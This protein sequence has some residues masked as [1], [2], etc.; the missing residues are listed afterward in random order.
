MVSARSSAF[1]DVLRRCRLAAG[2]TQEELAERAGL[3]VR[4]I[5]DLER[6]VKQRPRRDTVSLL[7]DALGLTSLQ[8]SL[9][10]DAARGYFDPVSNVSATIDPGPGTA[11]SFP[12]LPPSS[13][14]TEARRTNLPAELTSFVGRDAEVSDLCQL[15]Q[16]ETFGPRLVTLTGTGGVG[17]T[18][19]ALCVGAALGSSYPDGVWLVELAPLADPRLVAP[20]VAATFG[21]H[22]VEGNDLSRTLA[23]ALQGRRLL[24]LLDNCEHLVA[25]CA[26]L[27][28]ALLEDCPGL[29]VVATSREILGVPGEVIWR[30]PSLSAPKIE[31]LPATGSGFVDV[32]ARSEAARLFVER[33]R[34][35]T[36]NFRITA[37]NA[38]ALARICHWLDGIPLAIELAA[39][40]L[41][42]IGVTQLAERFDQRFRLLTGGS[43]TV[44]RRQQTL[45]AT[46]DWSY[47]LLSGPER[48]LFRRLAVFAGGWTLDAAEAVCLGGEIEEPGTVFVLLGAL[49]DKSLVVVEGTDG[50]APRYRLLDTLREYAGEQLRTGD[51]VEPA[52]RAH[53]T[54]YLQFCQRLSNQVQGNPVVLQ[55]GFLPELDNFRAAL[56]W[57]AQASEWNQ[58]AELVSALSVSWA[59]GSFFSESSRWIDLM[60]VHQSDLT[61]A[62]R[63]QALVALAFHL[64][65]RGNF[66]AAGAL[67]EQGIAVYRCTGHRPALAWALE[68]LGACRREEGKTVEAQ[69]LLEEA[70][71]VL[72]ELGDDART[73]GPRAQL[74]LLAHRVG[75]YDRAEILLTQ[76]LGSSSGERSFLGFE[77]GILNNLGLIAEDRGDLDRAYRFHTRSIAYFRQSGYLWH[78]PGVLEGFA[79]LAARQF[80]AERAMILAGAAVAIR[81]RIGSPISPFKKPRFDQA[82]GR[83]CREL[84]DAALIAWE[85][86]QALTPEQAIA[87]ALA[88]N[89]AV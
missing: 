23:T 19:L 89:N 38:I 45:R 44:L 4:G 53:A 64:F 58:W 51:E 59:A 62:T 42:T 12:K 72:Q 40:C 86:G 17:K 6:G 46:V 7:A 56:R 8:R 18:R 33:A 77:G 41:R 5:S 48:S 24:L 22:G 11:G 43:R 15:L 1:G 54:Y 66:P 39:S 50:D 65:G 68:V 2:L 75:D 36:P 73:V 85:R 32:V 71:Q 82:V 27:V 88:E 37:D 34:L 79:S 63:G 49:V 84:G 83:A 26:E 57:F 76:C 87:F 14:W 10:D 29:R 20:A 16:G 30:V 78:L 47:G 31:E 61:P 69:S 74:G 70:I 67:V 35:A 13:L 60:Q 21:I 55:S 9:L 3:S 81:E 25:S 80:Q 28:A 52:Q